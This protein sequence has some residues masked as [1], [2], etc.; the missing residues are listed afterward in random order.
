LRLV[1]YARAGSICVGLLLTYSILD[2]PLRTTALMVM[3]A[4]SC[5]FMLRVYLDEFATFV[6]QNFGAPSSS[7]DPPGELRSR[8]AGQRS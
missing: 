8:A 1:A 5:A 3:V 6:T 7:I 4:I 2:Y